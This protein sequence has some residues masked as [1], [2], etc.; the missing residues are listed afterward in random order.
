MQ[1]PQHTEACRQQ[2]FTL[3]ELSIVLVIIGLIVGGVL[4]GQDMIKAAQIRAQVTQLERYNTA[5]NTFRS[6]YNGLPGD[7]ASPAN[8]FPNVVITATHCDGAAAGRSNGNGLIES[9]G[10][11]AQGLDG[12][13]A[14][15][16]YEMFQANLTAE[17]IT[18]ADCLAG[19]LTL[20][21]SVLPLAKLGGGNYVHVAAYNGL[22]YFALFGQPSTAATAGAAGDLG[23][24]MTAA[25]TPNQ[26]YQLDSKID[27]G[28]PGSG[29]VQSGG[30][31]A[32]LDAVMSNIFSKNGIGHATGSAQVAGDCTDTTLNIYA[33]NAAAT[34]DTNGCIL[35]IRANF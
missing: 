35:R 16:W 26:A 20:S 1:R 15:F 8:F 14:I 3:I 29:T 23:S 33:S 17:N 24:A 32:G 31:N 6:K 18:T 34:K 4:T 7:L 10:T 25:L 9:S 11:D 22:N 2:G 19:N 30:N 13:T 27:D 5:V 21:S 12:E 28:L